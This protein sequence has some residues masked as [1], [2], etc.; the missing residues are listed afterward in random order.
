[1]TALYML[2]GLRVLAHRGAARV[3]RPRAFILK[4]VFSLRRG[5]VR[6]GSAERLCV[7]LVREHYALSRTRQ[8]ILRTA[9]AAKL[10]LG[11]M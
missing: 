11:T 2:L 9:H 10:N 7:C 4:S 3:A 5:R 6:W 1:M 8:V